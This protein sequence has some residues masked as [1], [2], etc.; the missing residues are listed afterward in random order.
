[1]SEFIVAVVIIMY[2]LLSNVWL[3][4]RHRRHR[5]KKREKEPTG[6]ED[7]EMQCDQLA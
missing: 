1:M 3:H 5:E 4:W 7:T 2:G 6:D